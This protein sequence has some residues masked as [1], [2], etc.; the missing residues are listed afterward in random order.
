MCFCDVSFSTDF[1]IIYQIL[2][3]LSDSYVYNYVGLPNVIDAKSVLIRFYV[4]VIIC[5]FA[6]K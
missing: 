4:S 3:M 5:T 2:E 6:V 1:V